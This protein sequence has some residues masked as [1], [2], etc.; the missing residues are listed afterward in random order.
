MKNKKTKTMIY[1]AFFIAIEIIMVCIPFLGFIP[2]GFMNA[3]TLHIP[4]I[5]AGIVLGCKGGTII[6]LVFGLC[7]LTNATIN[8]T[9]TSFVF[10]PFISGNILSLCIAI[11][12]RMLCGYMAGL[13]YSFFKKINK[14]G[15][16]AIFMSGV[17]GSLMN[18][19]FVLGGIYFIFGTMYSNAIG[20]EISKL[21]F[22]FISVVGVQAVIEALLGSFIALAIAKPLLLIKGRN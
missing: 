12:P 3:T 15:S 8:P 16:V 1:Y 14:E 13:V 7:S 4:V 17:V 11:I 9:I 22:Y 19:L 20:I 5:V 21:A 6:G 18:T 2:L 10:S